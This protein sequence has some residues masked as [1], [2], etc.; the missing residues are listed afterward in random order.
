MTQAQLIAALE[1]EGWDVVDDEEEYTEDGYAR[2]KITALLIDGDIIN[3]N[4]FWYYITGGNAYWLGTDPT[5]EI[6]DNVTPYLD[7]WVAAASDQVAYVIENLNLPDTAV[8]I[9]YEESGSNATED[10][11]LVY[12]NSSA[13]M[14]HR[15]IA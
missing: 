4:Y 3:R 8:V 13:T 6:T 9:L 7:T 12:R 10:R 5:V 2:H 11:A 1:A 15:K 14:E